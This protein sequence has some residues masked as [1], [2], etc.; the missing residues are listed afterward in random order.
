MSLVNVGDGNISRD[1][2]FFGF[3]SPTSTGPAGAGQG[4]LSGREVRKNIEL[5][6]IFI[7]REIYVPCVLFSKE[8]YRT[9]KIDCRGIDDGHFSMAFPSSVSLQMPPSTK[10][11]VEETAFFFLI[12]YYMEMLNSVSVSEDQ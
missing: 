5:F 2:G 8:L 10:K 12:R 6:N 7:K 11:R 3:T 4:N 1:G 9:K